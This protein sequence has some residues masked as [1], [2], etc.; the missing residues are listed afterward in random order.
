ME[1]TVVN[2]YTR[3]ERIL[4]IEEDDTFA[5][6][7]K[8]AANT[9]EF[10]D[11]DAVG[12]VF[13]GARLDEDTKGSAVEAFGL[14]HG[15]EFEIVAPVAFEKLRERG[16]SSRQLKRE[17]YVKAV[18]NGDA[19]L[20]K[21]VGRNHVTVSA[22]GS[23]DDSITPLQYAVYSKDLSVVKLVLE[24]DPRLLNEGNASGRTAL[25]MACI[26][27]NE[28]I[29]AFLLS[30]PLIA[31]HA[32]D[33]DGCTP[34]C[35]TVIAGHLHIMRLL[36]KHCGS[37]YN[38]LLPCE[39]DNRARSILHWAASKGHISAFEWIIQACQGAVSS[40]IWPD[41][42]GLFPV[43]YAASHTEGEQLIC[44]LAVDDN[45]RRLRVNMRQ[46]DRQGCTPLHYAAGYEMLAALDVLAEVGSQEIIRKDFN[47]R[48]PMHYAAEANHARALRLLLDRAPPCKVPDFPVSE[49]P[50]HLAVR[51]GAED[52]VRVLLAH[53]STL[54]NSRD[55][56]GNTPLH[57]A[58][59]S[60]QDLFVAMLCRHKDTRWRRNNDGHGPNYYLS[61]NSRLRG[62][63]VVL[64]EDLRKSSAV[65]SAPD[66]ESCGTQCTIS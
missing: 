8:K 19:D 40:K 49:S 24:N 20:I 10:P 35:C 46:R 28:G 7:R 26:I 9:F 1:V 13:N 15:D 31:C 14:Q 66:D 23:G 21:L 2:S 18:H 12:I 3:E 53:E 36:H 58:V 55:A 43:H 62:Y 27:G 57:A 5:A 44:H 6:F 45:A 34:M 17:D 63:L 51:A 30:Q 61:T 42:G 59:A 65:A 32:R 4:V 39:A 47:M 48:T 25:H 29:V 16:L 64:L 54:V 56:L 38:W 41:E 37:D 52:S 22:S 11:P 33:N 50:L 60:Q